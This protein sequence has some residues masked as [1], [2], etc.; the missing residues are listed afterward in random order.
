MDHAEHR[1]TV[2]L[3]FRNKHDKRKPGQEDCTCDRVLCPLDPRD[4][5]FPGKDPEESLHMFHHRLPG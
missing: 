5:S 4:S 2:S 3:T 1:Q